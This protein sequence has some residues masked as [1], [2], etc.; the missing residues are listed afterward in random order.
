MITQETAGKIWECYREIEAG[1]KLLEDLAAD[2]EKHRYDD[3]KHEPKLEDA[4]GRHKNLQL[5]V[6]S[7]QSAYTLFKVHPDM[8][9]SVI[10]AHIAD[11]RAELARLNEIA[12]VE[13]RTE[14]AIDK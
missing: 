1:N 7:G 11:K 2:A 5:G 14:R 6:P 10:R 4:F 8:A 13:A 3:D 12:I 9:I